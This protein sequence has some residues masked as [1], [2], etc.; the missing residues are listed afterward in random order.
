MFVGGG[1]V[2]SAGVQVGEPDPDGDECRDE[3]GE[4][5]LK[6]GRHRFFYLGTPGNRGGTSGPEMFHWWSAM[7][8]GNR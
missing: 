1:D 2:V 7:R 5:D 4:D 6:P 3:E 8:L